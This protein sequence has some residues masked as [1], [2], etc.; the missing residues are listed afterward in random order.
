MSRRNIHPSGSLVNTLLGKH[1][2]SD[3]NQYANDY[4]EGGGA[5][6]LKDIYADAPELLGSAPEPVI[7]S[8]VDFGAYIYDQSVNVIERTGVLADALI[9]GSIYA[10]QFAS[11]IFDLLGN[12]FFLAVFLITLAVGLGFVLYLLGKALL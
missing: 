3:L 7:D 5:A 4:E 11:A 12:N 10:F 2:N 8:V 9:T 6:L 1:G